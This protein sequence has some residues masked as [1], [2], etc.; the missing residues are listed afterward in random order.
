[1]AAKG[2]AWLVRRSRDLVPALMGLAV[3][4]WLNGAGAPEEDTAEREPANLNVLSKPSGNLRLTRGSPSALL[5]VRNRLS[6]RNGRTKP[7]CGTEL[8]AK[9]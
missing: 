7:R 4:E 1:M 3:H 8:R 5:Q 6:Q 2:T 9:P